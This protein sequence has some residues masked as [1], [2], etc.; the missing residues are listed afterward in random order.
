MTYEVPGQAE[1]VAFEAQTASLRQR[2]GAVASR[3]M[4]VV[5]M[6]LAASLVGDSVPPVNPYQETVAAAPDCPSEVRCV[7]DLA[8]LDGECNY[9]PAQRPADTVYGITEHITESNLS[10]ALREFRDLESCISPN[11]LIDRDGTV[12]E[13]V[14]PDNIAYA[15]GNRYFNNHYIQVEHVGFGK[16]RPVV[17]EEQLAASEALDRYLI[18]R[19]HIKPSASTIF[20]HDSVP[21]PDD[22]HVKDMH[23]DPYAHWPWQRFLPA[24]GAPAPVT[25]GADGSV[26]MINPEGSEANALQLYTGP[27]TQDALASDPYLH[28]DG[29]PGSADARDWGDKALAGHMYVVA[30]HEPG[31]TGIYYGGKV[32]WFQDDGRMAVPVQAEVVEPKGDAPVAIYGRPNLDGS[33]APLTQYAMQPGQEYVVVAAPSPNDAITPC[34]DDSCSSGGE[35]LAGGDDFVEVFWNGRFGFVKAGDVNRIPAGQAS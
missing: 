15:A 17:T 7:V 6:G 18:D 12:Y 33:Q 4:L 34:A 28:P 30:G 16:D 2:M 8:A 29:A 35:P 21:S 26:V 13:I 23:T 1:A 14:P 25:D 5:A 22:K 3:A 31:W 27:S 24:V 20:G 11:Y 32:V 9:S 19:Y 10:D